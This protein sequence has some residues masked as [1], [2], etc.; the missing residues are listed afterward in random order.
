ME[1]LVKRL[2]AVT[3]RLE[4][5]AASGGAGGGGGGGGGEASSES[6]AEFE[7]QVL[8]GEEF[9]KFVDL[10]KKIGGEVADQ[11]AIV[12]KCFQEERALLLL[13]SKHKNPNPKVFSEV[14][15]PVGKLVDEVVAFAEKRRGNKM[16]NHF[17]TVKEG[18][19][20]VGWIT[21]APKPAPYVKEMHDQAQFYG[22]RVI[23]E[24]KDKEK[25]SPHVEWV[26]AYFK[27]IL[28]LQ[29]YVKEY[30]TTG[31]V[32]NKNGSEL[33]SAP[34]APGGGPGAPPPPPPP[35]VLPP[36]PSGGGGG[37][38]DNAAAK[39]ANLL[40]D[41]SK[42]SA[43]TS[44]LKKVTDD[45][46]T[47]KNPNLRGSS[48]V[49]ATDIKPKATTA[50]SKF[51]APAAK[52]PPK[53]Q[54]EGKKWI[55]EYQEDNPNM[56]I[57]DGN[58]K[59]T[60]YVF[61]CVK[62]T[63]K[64]TGKVNS[65]CLDNCKKVALVF[66]NVISSIEVVN[67]QSIQVQMLGKCPTVSIDKTDGCQVFLSKDSLSAEI[68]SAKSS[69]MNVCIPKPDGDYLERAIPEQFKTVWN[70]KSLVTTC[71]DING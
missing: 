25:N 47:H 6:V 27:S 28:A 46:K 65:I 19:G 10:S 1:P 24:Y 57:T 7:S 66:D 63:I 51:T 13:A 41:I 64:V 11:V 52:K 48:V 43:V 2:E 33:T 20:C 58:S 37:G 56:A 71:S 49:K 29:A 26:R 67:S 14:V 32:W 55:V 35:A 59:Q 31:L 53:L 34:A 8:N 12:S 16:F 69:E 30:H 23:K 70:G 62:S 50:G 68:V 17:M 61:R 60:V 18:I 54:L 39:R 4:T 5:L 3:S 22:N 36:E 45:M 44:G 9:K 21:V 15:K 42:G 38:G 40:A